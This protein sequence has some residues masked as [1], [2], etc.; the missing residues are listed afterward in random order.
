MKQLLTCPARAAADCVGHLGLEGVLDFTT[1]L[2]RRTRHS[3]K[4]RRRQNLKRVQ[5]AYTRALTYGTL[6]RGA[7]APKAYTR[8]DAMLSERT[9]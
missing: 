9:S 1:A 2:C 3:R 7:H 8:D 4:T 6:T 5:V